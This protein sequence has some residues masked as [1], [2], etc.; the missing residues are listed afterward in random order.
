VREC[1]STSGGSFSIGQIVYT[2]DELKDDLA[3]RF[4]RTK[5]AEMA[6]SG[7][8]RLMSN[9]EKTLQA[10]MQMLD[11]A[12][13]Q[14]AQ[15]ESQI[16]ALETQNKMVEMAS[17]DSGVQVD[18]SKLAQTEKLISDIKKN[19]TWPSACWLTRRS[20]STR[21]DGQQHGQRSRAADRGRCLPHA[22]AAPKQTA[23]SD[24]KAPTATEHGA[25]V[26]RADH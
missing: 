19:S 12:Q 2:R 25:E 22:R 9:R 21:S 16:A 20:S 26:S 17:V 5:E 11:H 8:R 10:S 3:R 6:L 13:S 1:L 15:L 18:H 14:R 23:K 7:K 4:E 24:E